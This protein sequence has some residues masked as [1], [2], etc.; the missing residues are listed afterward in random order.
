MFAV[1]NTGGK[2]YLVKEGQELK[3]EKLENNDGDVI[4]FE[5]LLVSDDEGADTKI[6]TPT[7]A[8]AKVSAKVVETGKGEKIMVVKY[9]PKSRYRR[10]NGH[11]QP[12]TKIKIEKIV[13]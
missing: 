7:V 9:K 8:G 12:F 4:E 1:I 5:A 3:V 6:G 2:Q 11:R 10:K 13:A